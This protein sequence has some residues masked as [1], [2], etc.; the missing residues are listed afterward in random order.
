MAADVVSTTVQKSYYRNGQLREELPLWD[1]RRHGIVR[2][3][4]K[5]GALASEEPYQ[6]GL[7]HGLCRQWNEA[8]RLLGEYQ[9]D[10]G[11]GAQR[12]WHDN[13]QLQ[14]EVSTVVG[15]FCGRNRLWLRDGTLISEHIYL[16]GRIVTAEEYHAAAMDDP[17][18]PKLPDSLAMPGTKTR[19]KQSHTHRVFVASL[20]EKPNRCEARKWLRQ[21]DRTI[22]SLGRFK[23]EGDAAK[24]VEELY[25]A[26]AAEVTVAE[27][28]SNKAGNQF[29]DC[30]LVRLPQNPAKRGTIRGVSAQLQKR[31]LGAVEPTEDI[32]ESYLYLSLA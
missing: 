4:H 29:A 25:R 18:L 26:G 22:R 31:E 16:Y 10:R 11:T 30:L 3:W 20:L 15:E 8:G 1:G 7:L 13:G 24:F 19:A 2:T 14:L 5:N 21:E 6:D 28:Y 27:I 9:M 32:G 23:S 17:R 12:A